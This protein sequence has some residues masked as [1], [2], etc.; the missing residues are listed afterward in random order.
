MAREKMGKYN[1]YYAPDGGAETFL[2]EAAS[3]GAA[4][5]RAHRHLRDGGGLAEAMYETARAAGHVDG[6]AAPDKSAE[7]DDANEWLSVG[8]GHY[9]AV[10]LSDPEVV[11]RPTGGAAYRVVLSIGRSEQIL[12]ELVYKDGVDD[13]G[14]W[15]GD[16]ADEEL[17]ALVRQQFGWSLERAGIDPQTVTVRAA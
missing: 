12:G 8:D 10:P 1:V 16:V 5:A 11:L 9:V 13:E 17:D 7:R 3:L 4:T 15:R 2:G 6:M 14:H